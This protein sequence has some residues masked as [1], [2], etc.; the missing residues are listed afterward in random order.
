MQIF[1]AHTHINCLGNIIEGEVLKLKIVEVSCLKLCPPPLASNDS[2]IPEEAASD[3]EVYAG[4][5]QR[6]QSQL[7]HN[8]EELGKSSH[9]TRE[10]S[11][12]DGRDKI[13][14]EMARKRKSS[15][16]K[17]EPSESE[18]EIESWSGEGS[19][20]KKF[21][22]RRANNSI[23]PS[24]SDDE[25][26]SQFNNLH[27][28][29][30]ESGTV[31]NDG[32]IIA[33]SFCDQQLGG[34]E[35]F[36]RH[37]KL[38]LCPVICPFEGCGY[39]P[40]LTVGHHSVYWSSSLTTLAHH[41]KAKHTHEAEFQCH[42]C[43]KRLV[44]PEAY[45]YHVGQHGNALK[46]YCQTCQKFFPARSKREHRQKYHS[47]RGSYPCSVCN[48]LLSTFGNLKI[49]M[50]V[51]TGDHAYKCE[52]CPRKFHQKNNWLVHCLRR[53]GINNAA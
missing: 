39:Q 18:S 41:I 7:H 3:G 28:P 23:L 27:L 31:D 40:S 11:G 42:I 1:I 45:R 6:H 52:I 36:I 30:K 46:F 48:K 53:H 50:Q 25:S 20:K 43:G 38:R 15:F 34:V 44:T 33:C 26:Q 9:V 14:T 29:L 47:S 13:G 5:G 35:H 24:T 32:A 4:W 17:A 37:L 2:G 19:R 51:H 21:S 16:P 49:H 22:N 8:H 12:Q 10:E